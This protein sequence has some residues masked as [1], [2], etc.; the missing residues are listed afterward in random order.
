MYYMNNEY[1]FT[2]E[3]FQSIWQ[4]LKEY[5]VYIELVMKQKKPIGK[6]LKKAY[7]ERLDYFDFL[8]LNLDK[9][10]N[11]TID[12]RDFKRSI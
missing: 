10:K 1:C 12:I 3:E 5:K 11:E 6:V 4:C 9:I 7:N 2:D 8:F